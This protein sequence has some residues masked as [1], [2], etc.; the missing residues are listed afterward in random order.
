MR[1]RE[2]AL[3]GAGVPRQ[4]PAEPLVGRD[5]DLALIES[6][7]DGTA[8]QGGAL[9]LVGDAGVG[10]TAM[11]DTAAARAGAAGIRVLRAAGD[12]FEGQV[13]F[14]GLHQ[15]LHP[16]LGELHGLG[17][18]HARALSVALGLAEGPQPKRLVVSNAALALLL[19]AAAEAPV[20]VIVDDLPL[21]DSASAIV[22]GFVARRLSGTP[23]TLMA[24]SRSGE[25][26][27]FT[28][29]GLPEHEV[30]PL[31]PAAA[32]ELLDSRFPALTTRV[33]RRLLA[34]AQGNPLA[35]L[36]LPI[37]LVRMR[38][39]EAGPLP[40]VLP[41]SRRLQA[42]FTSHISA[43]PAATR[44]LL[45]LAALERTGDLLVLNRAAEGADGLDD[46]GP[47]ERA[48]LVH[49][50]HNTARL[51][52]RHP[53]TRSALVELS[54]GAERR[55][56]H[57]L[58]AAQLVDQPER[59]AWHLADSLIGPD[60]HVAGLLDEVA[61]AVLQRGDAVDAITT[62][63]RAAELSPAGA[64]QERR[65]AEAAYLGADVTGDLS[66]VPRL[67]G[68]THRAGPDRTGSLA[69]AVA[70]ASH[71]L[72]AD[73][74]VDAAHRLL[75]AA[76]D[77]HPRPHRADDTTVLEALHVL[78]L[79]CF[80][81]GRAHLWHPFD[82]AVGRLVPHAPDL[83]AV[84]AGT[85]ADPA[86][87]ALPVLGRLDA[88]IADLS[89]EAHPA[90][91]VRIG[92]AAVYVDR[93][94]GCRS[95]LW[96]VVN[97]GRAG[98]AV[99]SAID[100]LFLLANDAFM[101]G[102]WDE[103]D[104]LT[105]EGLALCE[106]HG[107][108]LLS[109]P[110]LFL[111]ALLAAVRGDNSTVQALTN[112]MISWAAPRRVRAVQIY[113]SHVKALTALARGD[114]NSAYEHLTA[115]S[116]AGE[117]ASHTPHALWLVME[118]TEAAMRSGRPAEA[119]A[120]VAAAQR[121]GLSAISPRLALVTAGAAAMAHPDYLERDLFE[122]ALATPD[123]DRWP[124][125]AA[126]IRLAYGERL[127]RGHAAAEART[128]ITAAL[129]T[130]QR[131]GAMSWTARATN[132]LRATGL[133][134]AHRDF[135]AASLTP[136]QQQIA[137][138]AATGLTNKQIAERLYLSPRTVATHLHQLF[139]KLGVTS[140]AALRD[141]LETLDSE[142]LVQGE[143]ERSGPTTVRPPTSASATHMPEPRPDS[144]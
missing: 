124:F 136:Q 59:R 121:A 7:V 31:T 63:L 66:N 29:S 4:L 58:L 15:V 30:R 10:K 123:A 96:R 104:R 114:F 38:H 110:G 95:A 60:E 117:L 43:L 78:L 51:V 52:F 138:L 86:R 57:E 42:V 101:T 76:I 61:Y 77:I 79:V 84:L 83:L 69:M 68:N 122:A 9:L 120:H 141:A 24:A 3:N 8:G 70:A 127:R 16:V 22:L 111:R 13:S 81:G 129:E 116:R 27:F 55:R 1:F 50:D 40:V 41:L 21:L 87:R 126:R 71:L 2:A 67:L 36:E 102:Q 73:G 144:R 119:A 133:V 54:T 139:P 112:Q 46:L 45:L 48:G 49:V 90:R 88:L 80:F 125:D 94:P 108:Q 91:I 105:D 34:D 64:D 142:A 20:L 23:V 100:A 107:Y 6:F 128:H 106:A 33:R 35:L 18:V 130:F 85:F 17:T 98:G 37:A 132:E 131:L 99:A 89:M 25:V 56:A 143:E 11:L 103:L 39:D 109:W 32:A 75:V 14:A 74:D 44:R 5:D 72:N 134:P 97:D 140:R 53:L 47:A 137:M 113:A 93:L 26:S 12:H 65:L 19:R 82:T 115:V 118:L 92:L 28:G 62:L 135:T